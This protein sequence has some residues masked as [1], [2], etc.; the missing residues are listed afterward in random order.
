M[1]K[2]KSLKRSPTKEKERDLLKDHR[3]RDSSWKVF[4]QKNA[5]GSIKEGTPTTGERHQ[6]AE[7]KLGVILHRSKH[8]SG[9]R[10]SEKENRD[11]ES[12]ENTITKRKPPRLI[13]MPVPLA[14]MCGTLEG[15]H[16]QTFQTAP[17]STF[18]KEKGGA[19]MVS[20]LF[21]R[22]RERGS[23]LGDARESAKERGREHFEDSMLSLRYV[24]HRRKKTRSHWLERRN[25]LKESFFRLLKNA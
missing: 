24:K 20:V 25:S 11:F 23:T 21:G 8:P 22:L 10:R 3:E 1:Q 15:E 6:V 16:N 17:N 9:E 5:A 19:T 13:R 4:R 7:K 18:L 2:K 12:Q 14:K